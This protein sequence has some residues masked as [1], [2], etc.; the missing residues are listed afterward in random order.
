MKVLFGTLVTTL[1]TIGSRGWYTDS[2]SIFHDDGSE[3][4]LRGL[5]WFGWETQDLC[6]DG[7]WQNPMSFYMENIIHR[8][9]FNMIR[10]P[11][12][13]HWILHR[14]DDYPYSGNVAAD[15]ECQHRMAI[16]ILDLLFDKADALGIGIML[17]LHRLNDQYISELWYS[18]T[19]STY[20]SETWF[21]TWFTV[22]DRYSSR[23][24]LIAIDLLNEPHGVATWGSGDAST[25]WRLFAETA[26][27]R[28]Q[29]RYPNSTWLYFVEGVSWGKDLTQASSF[30]VRMPAGA[31]K[32][33]VYSC[34]NYGGSVIPS[35]DTS[36]VD[37][38]RQDWDKYF[39]HLRE[40]GKTV[41]PGEWGGRTERDREWMNHWA[42]YVIENGMQ[43]NFFWSLGP[44]SG[45]VQGFLLDDW[46]SVDEFKAEVIKRVQP[47]PILPLR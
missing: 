34:H 11:F 44:N 3:A 47:D 2:G 19:E 5:S 45:D 16:E 35:L 18:P 36:N 10:V 38:L 26:I 29:H 6:V 24:N 23:R 12:C 40:E 8:Y 46:T 17:D 37:A 9:G 20:T 14:L 21:D 4:R 39:G 33:L 42:D 43:N 15:P 31:E 7:L 30:P 25:D 1:L 22:L 41:V 13:S 28:I 32:R 27:A